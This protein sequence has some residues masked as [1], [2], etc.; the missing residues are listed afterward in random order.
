MI[1]GKR[2]GTAPQR[3]KA[4]RRIR[5]AARLAQAPWLGFDV[6]LIAREAI[7]QADFGTIMKD[8]NRVKA[9]IHKAT[10][11]RSPTDRRSLTDH[12]T[13]TDHRGRR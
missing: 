13:P 11:H 4:K 12:G 1:A 3:N 9:N 6:V 5:E 7:A 10:D 2:L 8:M